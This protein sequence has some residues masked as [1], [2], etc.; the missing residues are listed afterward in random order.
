MTYNPFDKNIFD[1]SLDDINILLEREIPEGY[2][3]EYKSQFQS[4]LKTARSIAS[5]ANM[6]GGWYFVGIAADKIKNVPISFQGFSLGDKNDPVSF[7]RDSIKKH[8]NK[9]PIFTT[10][11]LQVDDENAILVVHIPEDQECPYVTS[12]GRIYRRVGD[13]S[14]PVYETDQSTIDLLAKRGNT[15]YHEF[16]LFCNDDRALYGR[17]PNTWISIFIHQSLPR[18]MHPIELNNADALQELAGKIN[19]EVYA[20][21]PE[22]EYISGNIPFNLFIATY[23]SFILRQAP[24]ESYAINS[25]EIE[26]FYNGSCKIHIPISMLD[27]EQA[28]FNYSSQEAANFISKLRNTDTQFH[29]MKFFD[30][31]QLWFSIIILVSIYKNWFSET[32]EIEMGYFPCRSVIQITNADLCVPFFDHASWAIY[33]N[34]YGLPI[35]MKEN[36][37]VPNLNSKTSLTNKQIGN[38][39]MV[40]VARIAFAFGI[41]TDLLAHI[42]VPV[43]DQ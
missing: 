33:S 18:N 41:P 22:K 3:I 17:D 28:D 31:K 38:L 26:L 32:F 34:D 2:W 25:L 43:K 9:P 42:G 27:F 5:F 35:N 30:F 39:W 6:Y 19:K 4:P 36:I 10:K 8:I 15:K 7:F 40:T 20:S 12:D 11:L 24:N 14:D 37:Q 1:L 16:E 29:A 21:F 23:N 13:S